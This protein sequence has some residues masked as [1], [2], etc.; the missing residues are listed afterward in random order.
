MNDTTR[1]F[2]TAIV[3]RV[4]NGGR[5]VELRLF[6]AIRQGGIESGVAV[7]AVEPPEPVVEVV[8]GAEVAPDG[9]TGD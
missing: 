2:L 6:P 7:V 5:I 1:R 9:V 4:P 3:D 8:E